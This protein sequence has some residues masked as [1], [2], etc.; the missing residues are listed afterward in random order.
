MRS[1]TVRAADLFCGAGGTSMG[2]GRACRDL[3]LKLDLLAINHWP[4][5]IETHQRNHPAAVHLCETL[6]SVDPRAQ[7]PGGRLNLLVASPECI[8]H[9]PAKGG[10]PRNGQQR[11]SGWHVPRWLDALHVDSFIIENVPQ[12]EKWGPLNRRGFAIKS[13]QGETFKALMRAIEALDFNL[14]WRRLNSANYG[15]AQTRERLFVLG[16]KGRRT[17]IEWP[18][19]TH[20]PGTGRPWRPAKD[21]IDWSIPTQSIYG[22]PK[23]YVPKTMARIAEG[24]RR[25]SGGAFTLAQGGGGVARSVA[26]PVPTVT[27]DGAMRVIEPVVVTLRN[28][29][30]PRSVLEPLT[31]VAGSGNHHLLVEAFIACYYGTTNLHPV[32]APLPTVTPKDRFML[33]EPVVIDGHMLD[34]R[35]RM[36][37]VHEL[38][39]AQGFDK[40]ITFAG[41][42]TE[43]KKQIGNA[44]PGELARALCRVQLAPF[45]EVAED[46]WQREATA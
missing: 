28:H 10:K 27:C 2:M 32:S 8:D 42:K 15:D 29:T 36:F 14:E 20:G 12:W 24:I 25:F 45:A 26:D 44:V 31:T 7:V 19:A 43:Q 39:A 40:G 18:K 5:A 22:R 1:R 41:T 11:A 33:V 16:R 34:I 35:T 9:S 37:E 21:I 46:A 6:D 30:S 38:A 17:P 23:P 3:R 13:R 4:I